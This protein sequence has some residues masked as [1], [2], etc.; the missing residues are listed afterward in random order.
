MEALFR[1]PILISPRGPKF[2][3]TALL[4]REESD[5]GP[6]SDAHWN[7]SC[8]MSSMHENRIW[9]KRI[10]ASYQASRSSHVIFQ[11]ATKEDNEPSTI[12]EFNFNNTNG[13]KLYYIIYFSLLDKWDNAWN[14]PH[15]EIN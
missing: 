13:N 12:M 15:D 4:D 8:A 6:D 7:Q 3:E 9:N 14:Y 11:V 1:G 2:L 5:N 10:E